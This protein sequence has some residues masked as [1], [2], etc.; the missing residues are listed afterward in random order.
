[1][2]PEDSS[3]ESVA[4]VCYVLRI[5]VRLFQQIG[6]NRPLKVALHSG[7]SSQ[8]GGSGKTP[9]LFT[10]MRYPSFNGYLLKFLN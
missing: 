10:P 6:Q 5:A 3:G 1:L 4:Q 2:R 8:S 9:L 7:R